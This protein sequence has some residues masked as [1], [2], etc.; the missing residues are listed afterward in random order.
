MASTSADDAEKPG[1]L[2]GA[3]FE[4]GAFESLEGDF[5]EVLQELVGDKSL[6]R[7]RAEYEKL[8]R[9]LK[10][11]HE[12][13][14]RLIKTCKELNTNI[15]HNAKNIQ[16]ASLLAQED[17]ETIKALKRDV[18][19]AWKMVDAAREKEDRSKQIIHNLR[20]ELA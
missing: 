3:G 19:K 14:K 5:Q 2:S 1:A 7:F 18:N 8:H 15:Q 20:L 12:Q 17:S 10:K 13:E 16:E 6:E 4:S 11:S 9:A